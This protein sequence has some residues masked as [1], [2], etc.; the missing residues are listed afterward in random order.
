MAENTKLKMYLKKRKIKQLQL[1][2]YLQITPQYL[3]KIV[4]GRVRLNSMDMMQ[5]IEIFTHFQVTR[6][7]WRPDWF[8]PPIT[9]T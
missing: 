9:C 7:D 2:A 1:A 4:N 5:A 8:Q 3:N 6:E